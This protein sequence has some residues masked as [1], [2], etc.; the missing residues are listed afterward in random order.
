MRLTAFLWLIV[1]IFLVSSPP[2]RTGRAGHFFPSSDAHRS[3]AGRFTA[4]PRRLARTVQTISPCVAPI[5]I[6][7]D[8]DE[9]PRTRAAR[10]TWMADRGGRTPCGSSPFPGGGPRRIELRTSDALLAVAPANGGGRVC[11]SVPIRSD[12]TR[13]NRLTRPGRSIGRAGRVR[14][15]PW[16]PLADRSYEGGS[17]IPKWVDGDGARVPGFF[18]IGIGGDCHGNRSIRGRVESGQPAGATARTVAGGRRGSGPGDAA[19]DPAARRRALGGGGYFIA[20]AKD[21]E[22]PSGT[23]QAGHGEAAD[24]SNLPRVE[25]VKPKRG[26][27]ERTTNQPGTIHAFD[28]AELYAKVSGYVKELK[29]RPGQPGQDGRSPD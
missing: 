20:T 26:G 9:E 15:A 2:L 8:D 11:R 14:P 18:G 12:G 25:V 17:G 22:R 13:P 27:M 23:E 16:R 7:P 5:G 21:R 29:V 24:H 28:Y 19:P 4:K 10:G 1:G 3:F 6:Q